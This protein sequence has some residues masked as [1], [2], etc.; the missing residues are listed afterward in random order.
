MAKVEKSI[1]DQAMQ[2]WSE[3]KVREKTQQKLEE[4]QQRERDAEYYAGDWGDAE[5]SSLE[6]AGYGAPETIPEDGV[7]EEA[8]IMEDKEPEPSGG[9]EAPVSEIDDEDMFLAEEPQVSSKTESVAEQPEQEETGSVSGD[10]KQ[11]GFADTVGE[12]FQHSSDKKMYMADVKKLSEMPQSVPSLQ[13]DKMANKLYGRGDSTKDASEQEDVQ[14]EVPDTS[15]EG[16]SG[17]SDSEDGYEP[18]MPVKKHPGDR[19]REGLL[20]FEKEQK[21]KQTGKQQQAK[22]ALDSC[23]MSTIKNLPK[24][25]LSKILDAFSWGKGTQ[26]DM[27]IAWIY[28]HLDP[29]DQPA[30]ARYLSEEQQHLVSGWRGGSQERRDELLLRMERRIQRNGQFLDIAELLLSYIIFD[31]LG[32]REGAPARPE[33]VDLLPDGVMDIL[34]KAEAEVKN[35]RNQRQYRTGRRKK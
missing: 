3:A 20:E 10:R 8:V 24:P 1:L 35:M 4:E 6:E 27:V 5:P 34:L 22:G 30:M 16:E 21:A 32:F 14:E 9:P 33:D 23:Q 2:R 13:V 25:I 15:S 18:E 31:R 28:C 7:P 17:S 12:S 26:G 29:D 19:M 11:S